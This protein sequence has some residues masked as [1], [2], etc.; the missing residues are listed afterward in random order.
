MRFE[1]VEMRLHLFFEPMLQLDQLANADRDSMQCPQVHL[2]LAN[3]QTH[4]LAQGRNHAGQS[5]PDAPLTHHLFLPIYW[6][7]MPFLAVGTPSLVEMV[8]RHFHPWARG[9][10][11]DFSHTSQADASQTQITLWTIDH[12][13]FD[14]LSWC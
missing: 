7:L 14:D 6:G 4:H 10:I 9:K 12:P 5:D 2:D 3:R 1:L 13:V 11:D 8:V